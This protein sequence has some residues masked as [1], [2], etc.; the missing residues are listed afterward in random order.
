LEITT[1]LRRIEPRAAADGSQIFALATDAGLLLTEPHN[2][3]PRRLA[4]VMPLNRRIRANV[5]LTVGDTDL[6]VR[7]WRMARPSEVLPEVTL[8][9]I[10]WDG[11][12]GMPADY[13]DYDDAAG[14]APDTRWA[15]VR[16]GPDR[17]FVLDPTA[18][19]RRAFAVAREHNLG[20]DYRADSF[21]DRF[22]VISAPLAAWN[23]YAANGP[24]T[25]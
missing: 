17:R 14:A 2:L 13:Y 25:D 16:H 5:A 9:G 6:A 18:D 15:V 23:H 22:V 20:D 4:E 3:A 24:R 21:D 1:T 10:D 19:Y 12:F 8:T 7:D 11:R